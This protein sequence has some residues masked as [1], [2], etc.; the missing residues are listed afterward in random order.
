MNVLKRLTASSSP[1]F[2]LGIFVF[3]YSLLVGASV[4]LWVIPQL[5]AQPGAA[6]GLVVLDSIGFDRIARAKAGEIASLGWSAWELRPQWPSPAGIASAFY[7]IW[8]P[9]PSSM[10]PFNAAVHAI[11]ACVVMAILRNFFAAM[12]AL[13]GA[14]VFAL[15]TASLEWVDQFHR[16]GVFII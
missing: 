10:L 6:D 1:I 5:F 11:S 3:G 16:Y 15:N 14:L 4:Q 7:A 9:V 12:P 2:W 8:N 13:L